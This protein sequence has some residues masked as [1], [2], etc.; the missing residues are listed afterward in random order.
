MKVYLIMIEVGKQMADTE[1][2]VVNEAGEDVKRDGKE[3]GEII[4]KGLGVMNDTEDNN[5]TNN[6]WLHTG[7][8]G[9]I[10]E[11]GQITI[12]KTKKDLNVSSG[13]NVSSVEVEMM[14]NNHPEILEVAVIATPDKTLGDILHAFIV[15]NKDSEVTKE[16]LFDYAVKQLSIENSPKKITFMKELPKTA[17]G[18]ILKMQL[19]TLN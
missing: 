18:K 6:G 7:D 9:T 1:V 11:D 15:L 4:V 2:R 3:Q 17:S 19:G 16:E 13:N 14:F 8:I 10:N 12:I 5:L